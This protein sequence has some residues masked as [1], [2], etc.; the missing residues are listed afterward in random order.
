M[1]GAAPGVPLSGASR[2]GWTPRFSVRPNSVAHRTLLWVG[3]ATS[4]LFNVAVIVD[5]AFRQG[6]DPLA[7]PMSALSLG[8]NG[9]VQVTGFL[10]FGVVQVITA[11]AW[12]ASLAGGFGVSA[13]PVVK[14]ISG[15]AM[16]AAGLFSQD[17]ANGY[18]VGVLMPRIPSV[19]AVVHQFVSFVSLTAAVVGLV[20]LAIRFFREPRWRGWA[21]WALVSAVAMMGALAV[22]GAL[23]SQHGDA[24]AF[25]K[26]ASWMPTIYG[27]LVTIRLLTGED[28]RV[29]TGPH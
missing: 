23:S 19:H 4:V 1:T 12:R 9:W 2:R 7:Q 11:V 20:L 15:A 29:A 5:G 27:T 13:Y 6:Y 3:A 18:P 21:P 10:V 22:F 16:I 25:E 28:A 24:G 8:P 14:V 26:L 17:P